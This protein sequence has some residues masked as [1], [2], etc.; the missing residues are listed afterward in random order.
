MS[1]M[2]RLPTAVN[3]PVLSYAPGTPERTELKCA[4]GSIADPGLDI[5]IIIGGEEIRTGKTHP[6][7]APHDHRLRLG[8]WHEGGAEEANRAIANTLEA[9]REGGRPGPWED[10]AAVFLRAAE[11]L[12][13]H[14]A[15]D[16]ERAATMLGQSKNAFQAE[17]DSACEI[18][19]F[20]PFSARTSPSGS[21]STSRFRRRASGTGSN[22]G[23]WRGFVYA[24]SPLQL[25]GDRGQ[26]G[27]DA[28]PWWAAG[29]LWKPSKTAVL[30]GLL[31][32][33]AA[34]GGPGCRRE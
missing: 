31:H 24:V 18:I 3:E 17:I 32:L 29:V 26:P 19:G 1:G 2:I 11:L 6:V 23:R 33:Q 10:R 14:V 28:Q 25:H 30:S 27:R 8:V 20:L 21:S 15:L 5:P 34:R 7:R 4:L 13:D 22:T 9:R 12:F 16:A